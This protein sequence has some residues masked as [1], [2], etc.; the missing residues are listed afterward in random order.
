MTYREETA[1]NQKTHIPVATS[2]NGS[3]RKQIKL[4]GGESECVSQ[5]Y[6]RH[7]HEFRVAPAVVAGADAAP[8]S[9]AS[10][11]PKKNKDVLKLTGTS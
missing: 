3:G 8:H 4:K 6:L 5:E 9:V 10:F 1:E 7:S 11:L 2:P